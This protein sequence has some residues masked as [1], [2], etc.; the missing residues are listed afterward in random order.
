MERK[1]EN[2]CDRLELIMEKVLRIKEALNQD[3]ANN[4][5]FLNLQLQTIQKS[6][7]EYDSVY[8]E[9]VSL[10]ARDKKGEWKNDKLNF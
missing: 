10:V 1:L 9:T 5:H 6:Y 3:A 8:N 4:V 7:E 2:L